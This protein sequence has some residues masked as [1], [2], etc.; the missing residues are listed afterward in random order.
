MLGLSVKAQP[1]SR[2]IVSQK[3]EILL[4]CACG[5]VFAILTTALTTTDDKQIQLAKKTLLSSAV[6]RFYWAINQGRTDTA[7]PET[8]ANCQTDIYYF[9]SQFD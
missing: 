2:R 6:K 7:V 4:S 8:F 3:F 5:D 1:K 9:D